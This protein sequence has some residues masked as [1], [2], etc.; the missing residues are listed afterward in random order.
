MDWTRASRKGE[1]TVSIEALFAGTGEKR[2]KSQ[3]LTALVR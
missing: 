3:D 1:M 2:L